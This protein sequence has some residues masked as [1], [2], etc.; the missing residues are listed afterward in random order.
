MQFQ[1]LSVPDIRF[2]SGLFGDLASAAKS[3]ENVA[4]ATVVMDGFLASTGLAA[5]LV[6]EL[7]TAGI[8]PRLY[9]DFS[10]EPKLAHLRA[11]SELARGSDLVI[12][13]G[14]GSAL[15]IAKIAACCAASD[16]DPM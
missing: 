8:E 7:V 6:D 3:F 4:V 1:T 15:D 2:A 16:E 10:G 9:C 11:A 5:A 14:G 12:G 13:I